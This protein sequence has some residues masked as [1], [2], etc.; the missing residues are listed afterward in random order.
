MYAVGPRPIHCYRPT[1]KKI[2]FIVER[3]RR[4]SETVQRHEINELISSAPNKH[5]LVKMCSRVLGSMVARRRSPTIV[6]W[7]S[8]RS[9]SF[10][11]PFMEIFRFVKQ[12]ILLMHSMIGPQL[13]PKI[14]AGFIPSLSRV[15][16]AKR[17]FSLI[18][19]NK[20]LIY[21]PKVI[22]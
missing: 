3:S 6:S 13:D 15:L 12:S 1:K 9:S 5:E 16:I 2:D 10:E 8:V 7:L 11:C 21:G 18:S 22:H 19:L 20:G 14:F 4:Y 17:C